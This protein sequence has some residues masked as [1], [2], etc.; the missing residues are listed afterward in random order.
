MPG[1]GIAGG[2]A[3]LRPGPETGSPKDHLAHLQSTSFAG[4]MQPADPDDHERRL[5]IEEVMA[6]T[7][8][9]YRII[10]GLLSR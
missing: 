4:L 1:A 8:E 3:L 10:R 5:R 2:A 7:C 6:N 9:H